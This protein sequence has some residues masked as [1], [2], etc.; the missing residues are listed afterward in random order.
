[1]VSQKITKIENDY[2]QQQAA[3][4]RSNQQKAHVHQVHRRRLIGFGLLALCLVLVCGVQIFR[5][6]QT[7]AD[8]EQRK[9]VKKKQLKQAKAQE[10]DLKVQVKQLHDDDY[11][12]KYIRYKYYYSKDGETIYSLPQDKAPNLTQQQ[13]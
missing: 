2:T 4:N 12:A 10:S 1:V 3:Q 6:H 11:L 8:I 13:K 7:L 9:T 5:T